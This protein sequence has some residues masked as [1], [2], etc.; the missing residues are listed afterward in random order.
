[1]L[2]SQSLQKVEAPKAATSSRSVLAGIMN[3][4]AS[5]R[6]YKVRRAGERAGAHKARLMRQPSLLRQPSEAGALRRSDAAMPAAGLNPC[7]CPRLA[8]CFTAVC[9]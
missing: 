9:H 1:M 6:R 2:L 5:M 3:T 7:L 8:A 4:P